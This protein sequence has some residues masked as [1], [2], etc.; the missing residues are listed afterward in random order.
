[1]ENDPKQLGPVERETRDGREPKR[2]VRINDELWNAAQEAVKWRGDP[3]VSAIMREALAIYVRKTQ[4]ERARQER[5]L[6]PPPDRGANLGTRR[7]YR[8]PGTQQ[9][10]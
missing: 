10:R 9:R 1:M 7:P 3:S 2:H 5:G 8:P 4:E 6:V